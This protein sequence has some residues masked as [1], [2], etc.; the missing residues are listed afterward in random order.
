MLT[1][2]HAPHVRHK[3][4]TTRIM[5]DVVIALIPTL[6]WGTCVFGLRAFLVCLVCCVSCV[7]FEALAQWLM[8]RPITVLDLSALVTGLLLGLNLP[9]TAPWWMAVVGSA[10]A[11]VVVKQIFGGLGHNVFNPALA[12]R[13]FLCLAWPAQMTFYT[14]PYDRLAF[15]A[16]DAVAS[17]TPLA[18]L[19]H[20]AFPEASLVDMLLGRCG[21]TIGE[22]S[23]LLLLV[24]GIY[25]LIR[26]VIT[27]HIPV[28][29]IGTV[30]VLTFIFPQ[31]GG[32]LDFMLYEILAGGLMI[33]AFFMATD[34]VTS[35]VTSRGRLLFGFGC[36]ALVVFIRYFGG[37]PEGVSFA[38]LIMNSL[39]W[40]IERVTRP[41]VFGEVK[42]KHGK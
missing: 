2:A 26:K 38:I 28:S 30:A 12:A 29:F 40:Y 10:F 4:S 37:Y 3:D 13:V 35:P 42:K 34:Y 27:W 15:S 36:G 14:A 7:G 6:A 11:I 21:G 16:V 17:A 19:K 8:H 32:R 25:L 31:T 9:S 18:S 23:A 33:G 5:L 39:V 1:V 41:R 24:G 22:V 20:A